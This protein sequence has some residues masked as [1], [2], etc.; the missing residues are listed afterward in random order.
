[1]LKPVRSNR[2]AVA[3]LDLEAPVDN[4]A[5]LFALVG[6]LLWLPLLLELR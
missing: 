4:C 2:T 5:L 6:A 3:L 1:M